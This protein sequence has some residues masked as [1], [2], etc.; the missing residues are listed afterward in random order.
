MSLFFGLLFI[1]GDFI[2]VGDLMR[3]ISLL[4]YKP[5]EMTIE[6]IARDYNPFW[7]TGVEVIIFSIIKLLFLLVSQALTIDF[8]FSTECQHR[9]SMMTLILRQ[10]I[11]SICLQLEGI[12]TLQLMKIALDWKLL[13]NFI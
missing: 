12:T 10:R 8:Y 6:E 13:G 3:S 2:V 11:L 9:F 1:T 7:L 4:L 5:V